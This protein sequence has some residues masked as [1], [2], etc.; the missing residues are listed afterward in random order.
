MT[1]LGKRNVHL[2][3]NAHLDPVW[4]W[5]WQEGAAATLS[6][7]RIA[8]ELCEKDGSFIF[9]HNEAVLYKWVQEY[10]PA[11][12]E[13]IRK[14][15]RAGRWHIMGGWY[16]QP[17]C[18]MPSGESIVRQIL[19]GKSYF[20]DNFDVD[21]ATAINFDPFGHSRGLVQIM[22]KS[23][24][25]SYMFGRPQKEWL[26]LGADDFVWIGYDGSE[27]LASRFIG[28]YQ[29]PLGAAAKT[30][31]ARMKDHP[32]RKVL[33]V[34]WGVGDHGGGPSKADLRDVN[35]LIRQTRT[36]NIIH[37]TP[38]NYFKELAQL[39]NQLPK[40]SKDLN[41][42]GVGCYTSMIR[43]KQK[44]RR[45]ENELYMAEK[46]AAAAECAGL[47]KYPDE[48]I[49]QAQV[50]LM[51]A[52][53]HDILPGSSIAAVEDA[54]LQTMDHGLEILSRIKLK[55]FFAMAAGQP[56]AAKNEIPILV[57]NPHPFKIKTTVE[58][59]FNLA[60]INFE[61]KFTQI[62]VYQKG[63][64]LPSQVEKEASNVP[65]DWRKC[66]IF[67]AQLEP[68]RMNR[69]D[70]RLTEMKK[71][72]LPVLKARADKIVFRTKD[73]E[74]VI[75]TRTGFVD[76]YR[77]GGVDYVG[78]NAFM[79]LVIADNEDPWGMT[80][81]SF[82]KMAGRFKLM[83]KKAAAKF[84]GVSKAALEPVRVI[85]DGDARSVVEALLR[86]EN[87]F[88]CQR[89]KL[90]KSGTEIEVAMDVHW[91]QKNQMLKLSVPAIEPESQYVGQTA[92]GV[93][94]LPANGDE[95]VSQKWVAVVS[96]N[97]NRALTCINDGI[98]GSDFSRNGLRLSLLRAAAYSGHPVEGREILMQDRYSPRID[99]GQRCF[100]LWFNAGAVKKRLERI[101]REALA[102]NEKPYALSFFPSGQGKQPKPFAMLSDDIVQITAI[103]KAQKGDD[104][105]IR[106][107]EPT[108]KP[109]A[110][111]LSLP[112]FG[113]KIKISLGGF[114][115]KTLRINPKTGKY[116]ETDLL[117]RK[118]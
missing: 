50:D 9:N 43:I 118:L 60:D 75:N 52:E 101:D 84:A 70:C 16:L 27:V 20:K 46:M 51:F 3:C 7:F 14:L 110:T 76:H 90:P 30:I 6:T 107:F 88:I 89:Y 81:V 56:T 113:K 78:K 61:E 31:K 73:L 32:D 99:Q 62:K 67:E 94:D 38:Q 55:A 12:F 59:E 98:Y 48:Q 28:W 37:S 69:F 54:A 21:V 33:A 57:Y 102:K 109:R 68:G 93:C 15:V 65:L 1:A 29:S 45:L 63:R 11:L 4:L 106:L 91:H 117:E 72:P 114:E 87:S 24:Y 5:Q 115:I 116:I 111:T 83:D 66:V 39:K 77:V 40:Y 85:E 86:F 82:R 97:S 8:A 17:D 79:P 49:A 100:N 10:E 26:K 71:K 95:A 44:H 80:V 35:Q 25:S 23:G 103:K 18:N 64:P 41:P 58:C 42:W 53:F 92:Y 105:I 13:R 47:L 96:K 36:E 22:S 19:T 108:G 104:Y 34:L 74:V 112:L 2:I